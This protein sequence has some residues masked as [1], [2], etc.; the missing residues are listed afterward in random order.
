MHATYHR[1]QTDRLHET[2]ENLRKRVS[3]QFG[4]LDAVRISIHAKLPI[5]AH[6]F[7][8][9][10]PAVASAS[11]IDIAFGTRSHLSQ[12]FG[13]GILTRAIHIILYGLPE[14]VYHVQAAKDDGGV[15]E[16]LQILR[17]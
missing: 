3:A 9:W 1:F 10:Q 15:E 17:E 6:S 5:T 13:C 8:C 12:S 16:Q 2:V 14:G 11:V 7:Q 4:S